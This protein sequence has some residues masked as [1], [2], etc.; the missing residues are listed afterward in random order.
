MKYSVNDFIVDTEARTVCKD[1]QTSSIRPRTLKLL[2]F[3]I[4]RAGTVIKKETL[5]EHVWDD[6]V[7]DEGVVFQSIS[8]IRKLFS[9]SQSIVNYP[10][11][12]YEFVANVTVIELSSPQSWY[13]HKHLIA[14][15]AVLVLGL[16]LLANFYDFSDNKAQPSMQS[17]ILI[18]PS[19]NNIEY[20]DNTWLVLGGMDHLITLLQESNP[21]VGFYSTG[22]VLELINHVKHEPGAALKDAQKLFNISGATHLVESTFFGENLDYKV[23][24]TIHQRS[25]IHQKTFLVKTLD[26]GLKAL[27]SEIAQYSYSTQ[28]ELNQTPKSEFKSTLFAKAM[29]TYESDWQEATSF[30]Q[31]YLAIEP[32]SIMATRYLSKLY[33]W[34][35]KA[36]HAHAL[37]NK[38]AS[39]TAPRSEHRAFVHFYRG[40]LAHQNNQYSLA[41]E[42][43]QQAQLLLIKPTHLLLTARIEDA[44]GGALVSQHNYHESL[45]HFDTALAYYQTI[46]NLVG[47]YSVQLQKAEALSLA[48][49]HAQGASLFKA[50]SKAIKQLNIVFLND[51]LAQKS[52]L[53]E[54]K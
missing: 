15:Y 10:R 53:F 47:S 49:K 14:I 28:L 25:H 40:L 37:L 26:Q 46:N 18:L 9:T 6:V 41:I 8:E 22:E 33:I 17:R 45:D 29:L 24:L 20:E 52:P 51:V 31:S 12:G 27:A 48:G 1:Q 3:F 35:Q 16:L 43:Y 2:L 4:E 39:L 19:Q 23:T 36:E 34:Q 21:K 54:N 11:K 30:L 7:V 32:D 13:L 50:A 38:L 5:L 44:I 42:E